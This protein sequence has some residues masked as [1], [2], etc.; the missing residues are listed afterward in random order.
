M[1][2]V[3]GSTEKVELGG[4]V[5]AL[6][7]V[8]AVH[9]L[10]GR[11][12]LD[13]DERLA[14]HLADVILDLVDR[15]READAALVAGVRLLELALAAPAGVDLGLHH[16]DRPAELLRGGL[17]LLRRGD[18]P[19]PRHRHA[20]PL[21]NRLRL[22]FVDVHGSTSVIPGRLKAEPGT[23]DRPSPTGH[24][25]HVIVG[26]GLSPAASPGMTS[27]VTPRAPG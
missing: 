10:A 16:P 21:E 26:S 1:M 4:D 24:G 11:A 17:G 14:E 6:L 15:A 2:P 22:V 25:Q 5:R 20:E 19:P 23:H 13:R 27:A 7:D 9:L 8:E 12:G 18:R 3:A